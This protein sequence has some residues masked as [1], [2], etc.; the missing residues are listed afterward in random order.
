MFS[1]LKIGVSASNVRFLIKLEATV[2]DRSIDKYST[3]H[4]Y[5]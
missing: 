5:G 1:Q 4:S 3:F 2:R